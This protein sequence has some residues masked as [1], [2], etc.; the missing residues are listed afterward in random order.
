[1]LLLLLLAGFLPNPDFIDQVKQQF[2]DADEQIVVVSWLQ[3]MIS[4]GV[5]SCPDVAFNSC[6]LTAYVP[7][8]P[9]GHCCSYSFRVAICAK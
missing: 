7:F 1:V 9:R 6:S 3:A 4:S 2:P 5:H 8:S